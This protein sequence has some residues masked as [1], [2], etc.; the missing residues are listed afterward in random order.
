VK[1]AAN[2][3]DRGAVGVVAALIFLLAMM[4][5]PGCSPQR[6]AETVSILM[7]IADT[8]GRRGQ[9]EHVERTT[10][11]FAVEGRRHEGDLYVVRAP[12]KATM[13]LIPGAA[14]A[15]RE[16]PRLVAFAN[17][18]A[19][20]RFEVFVPELER[21]RE[22]QVSAADARIL[23]DAALYMAERDPG[24]PLGMAALSFA[25]GPSVLALFEPGVES[26]ADFI[27]AVGGYYDLEQVITY[28][29]TGHYRATPAEPWRYRE[30]NA[31]GKWVFV[32][33]NA[34]RVDDQQ[35][36][37][38]LRRMAERKIENLAADVS[39]LAQRL[40]PEG[41][42][43]YALITNHDPERVPEL[44]E[45][46]PPDIQAEIHALDISRKPV[47]TLDVEFILIH[48]RDD[49]II[50]FTQSVALAEAVEPER[51]HLY[52][53][54]GLD[55]VDPEAPG[56]VDGF[57]MIQAV[58]RLLAIRDGRQSRRSG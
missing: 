10:I 17:T 5:L 49:A 37:E 46:L 31:Y 15:G 32:L 27:L 35:D 42:N 53:I 55:H 39:D 28:F 54:D 51:A 2:T 16:D 58:Y 19:R 44:L 11:T 29:T 38:I 7:E 12:P 13:I 26:R 50:P 20:A 52:L 56:L 9:R 25:L 48:G 23:A 40:G 4:P 43:I 22:L 33:S 8:A 24:R 34:Q 18:F 1:A 47:H 41:R 14:P 30:P 3:S 21:M 6:T 36:Q 45:A 57:K